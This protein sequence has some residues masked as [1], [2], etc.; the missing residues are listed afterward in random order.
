MSHLLK[1]L[2]HSSL[3]F[4]VAFLILTTFRASPSWAREPV[5]EFNKG[6][7]TASV[8]DD[9]IPMSFS[10]DSVEEVAR[11]V[12]QR[13]EP[14]L[15]HAA[16]PC[17]LRLDRAEIYSQRRVA[18][19]ASQVCST[20]E[21]FLGKIGIQLRADFDLYNIHEAANED[22]EAEPESESESESEPRFNQATVLGATF[23]VVEVSARLGEFRE[24]NTSSEKSLRGLNPSAD[25]K[26]NMTGE[27]VAV[28][29]EGV[30]I[31]LTKLDGST[32]TQRTVRD[33]WVLANV[34]HRG[35]PVRTSASTTGVTGTEKVSWESA[36]DLVIDCNDYL[37]GCPLPITSTWVTK[38]EV[39]PGVCRMTLA[40]E[41]AT[42]GIFQVLDSDSSET[43]FTTTCSS[44][45]VNFT[46]CGSS[47]GCYTNTWHRQQNVFVWASY[48]RNVGK[49]YGWD[50][51]SPSASEKLTIKMDE[52]ESYVQN[53]CY[54]SQGGACYRPDYATVFLVRN[55]ANVRNADVISHEV[56]HWWLDQYE[57]SD[58]SFEGLSFHEASAEVLMMATLQRYTTVDYSIRGRSILA[59]NFGYHRNDPI[60]G[61]L[62]SVQ[63][64]IPASA[65]TTHTHTLWFQ[66]AVWEIMNDKNCNAAG[67][68]GWVE[69]R[70]PFN[71][72]GAVGWTSSFQA[73]SKVVEA[74]ANYAKTCGSYCR[75][76]QA[77]ISIFNYLF[78]EVSSAVANNAKNIFLHHGLAI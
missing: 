41:D 9:V 10:G 39:S 70:G 5:F 23:N 2:Y 64:Q 22:I 31:R 57:V 27:L 19:I 67:S 15:L 3:R 14:F 47:D 49:S 12:L 7:I 72:N 36:G 44:P 53:V 66:Q 30:S 63:G 29:D 65:S 73:R 25:I 40:I 69:P 8:P 6:T 59:C 17:H 37:S 16:G 33:S 34:K 62:K 42:R 21:V 1:I 46:S 76:E 45:V 51:I 4:A 60:D 61:E 43:T 11:L 32:T 26:L 75:A 56:G 68:C 35:Y 71:G 38:T 52:E 24:I 13:I 78:A 20:Y 18:V 28:L 54:N 50:A 77:A 58:I 74:L 48:A 55:Q